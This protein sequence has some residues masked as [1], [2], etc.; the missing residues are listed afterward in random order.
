MRIDTYKTKGCVAFENDK[1]IQFD[2]I[3]KDNGGMVLINENNVTEASS[4]QIATI[5]AE[6]FKW[7][8]AWGDS[9][10]KAYLDFYDKEF[11]RFDGMKFSDFAN[12]KKSIFSKKEDKF[13]QFTKY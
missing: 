4:A 3:L 13:I 9:D 5:F 11:L 8:K 6:L 10:V 12:M 2:E 1:I 7:K